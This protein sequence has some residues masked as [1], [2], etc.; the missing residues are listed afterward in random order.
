[1]YISLGG[2]RTACSGHSVERIVKYISVDVIPDD[3][4]NLRTV[5]DILDIHMVNTQYIEIV[6]SQTLN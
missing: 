2:N 5:K 6:T 4:R 3:T 1:M